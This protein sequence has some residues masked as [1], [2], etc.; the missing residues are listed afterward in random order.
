VLQI[1]RF[2]GVAKDYSKFIRRNAKYVYLNCRDADGVVGSHWDD[3]DIS[4][5][6]P[7][8]HTSGIMLLVAAT[9]IS[10]ATGK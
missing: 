4:D 9:K 7:I 5:Y 6:D 1:E 3:K 2:K 10:Y 8:S